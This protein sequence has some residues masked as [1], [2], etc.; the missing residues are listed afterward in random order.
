MI[1]PWTCSH[2]SSTNGA[3]M[4]FCTRC[5]AARPAAGPAGGLNSTLLLAVG[6]ASL[7]FLCLALLLAGGALLWSSGRLSGPAVQGAI[8]PEPPSSE[9][10]APTQTFTPA[11]TPGITVAVTEPDSQATPEFGK[12]V[13]ARQVTSSTDP[14]GPGSSFPAGVTKI[15]VVFEYDHMSNDLTWERVWYLDGQ[16]ILRN[17]ENWTAGETGKFD[18]S[19]EAGGEPLPSGKWKLELYIKDHLLAAGN[20]DIESDHKVT[21]T[22]K[23]TATPA[24]TPTPPPAPAAQGNGGRVYQLAYSRWDGT[25][26]NVYVADTRGKNERLIMKRAAGPSWSPDGKRLFFMGEQ[27]VNQ[28][29]AEDNRVDC[30]FGTISDGI[31]AVDLPPAGNICSTHYGPWLCERKQIDVQSPPSDVCEE[32][33][34]K[35]FQNLDWKEGTA[36]WASVA[37][38]GA[39]VAYDARPGGEYRIYF[40]SILNNAQFRFEL[41]GEQGDWSPDGQRLVYRSGRDNQ[42]GLWIS[43]RDDTGHLLITNEGSDAF[44]AWSPDGRQITFSRDSGGGNIDIYLMNTDGSNIRRL[45]DAPGHDILPVYT[46]GGEIIF[47]SDRSGS[48]GIWKMS[49]SGGGQVEIIPNAGVGPDWAK[50]KMDV[51]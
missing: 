9:T 6:G 39:A 16:E 22:S 46:P 11:P 26:H 12:I 40:R 51:R 50:S 31:V 33:G 14:L 1:Q 29:L 17:A 23:P 2:C 15:H 8:T 45:T 20:F 4:R 47:R 34:F 49:G 41:L 30:D 36:R 44:P 38:D 5:G 32:N 21:P 13:F 19:L 10:V 28:Q 24:A 43:N 3:E 7:L 48:W 25:F 27:G 42:Q 37:P 35:V 18:Y